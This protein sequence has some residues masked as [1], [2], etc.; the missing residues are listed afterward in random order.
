MDATL[1]APRENTDCCWATVER[2]VSGGKH[3]PVD[4]ADIVRA[5]VAKTLR[6]P[7]PDK[8][9]LEIPE[10][11]LVQGPADD[12]VELFASLLEYGHTVGPEPIR[13]RTQ[14]N[15]T[16]DELRPTCTTE[17][18]VGPSEVPDFLKR[19]I[20]NTVRARRGEATIAP[21]VFGHRI[22]FTLPVDRRLGTILG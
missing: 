22:S 17:L 2:R 1:T 19:K 6:V 10:S 5:G 9:V 20:W 15:Y 18:L 4:F 3:P 11:V 13:L 8:L 21:A 7:D 14:I 12:L 16:F